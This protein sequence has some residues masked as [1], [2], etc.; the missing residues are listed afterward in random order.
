MLVEAPILGPTN[1][2]G[3]KV[4]TATNQE[5]EVELSGE[6]QILPEL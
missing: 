2:V 6:I 3:F 1:S 5:D 4:E